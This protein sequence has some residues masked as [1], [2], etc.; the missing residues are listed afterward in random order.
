[1]DKSAASAYVYAKACGMYAKSFIGK[2]AQKLFEAKTMGDLWTAVFAS[3]V[4][5]LPEGK[6]AD[7]LE[8]RVTEKLVFDFLKLIAAYDKPDLLSLALI[9]K[10]DYINVKTALYESE[11]EASSFLIDIFPYSIFNWKKWPDLK[12]VIKSSPALHGKTPPL[13]GAAADEHVLWDSEM[14]GAYYRSVW[15]GFNSL[16][17]ADKRSCGRLVHDE[18]I[19]QNIV[20]VLRLRTY[21]GLKERDIRPLLA[22]ADDPETEELFCRPAYFALDKPLDERHAWEKWQYARFLNPHEE[23]MPWTLDPRYVQFASDDYL[24]RLAI[25]QFHTNAFTVGALAAFFKIKHLEEYIIRSAAESLRVGT[26]DLFK[27]GF[28]G[29]KLYVEK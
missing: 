12:A 15:A 2:K 17:P 23:G 4:P 24:Y 3:E 13:H 20:W 16:S 14:D 18:I 11:A 5:V 27:S 6:L 19:L 10:Y 28:L 29:D 25:R 1:M 26:D 22:G 8:R 9:S 7:L 21:Y